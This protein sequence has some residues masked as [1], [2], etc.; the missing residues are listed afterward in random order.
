MA[1]YIYNTEGGLR[2][3][4]DSQSNVLDFLVFSVGTVRTRILCAS[5]LRLENDSYWNPKFGFFNP[6]ASFNLATKEK[7]EELLIYHCSVIALIYH[8]SFK[9]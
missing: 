7:K 3:R 4:G 6:R 9:M 5:S 8:C 1:L 2:R